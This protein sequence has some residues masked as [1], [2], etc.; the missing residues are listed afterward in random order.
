MR[1]ERL[2]LNLLVA[3]AVLI[4]ERSVSAA[5]RRLH[6]SQPAV[7][8]ALN[9]LRDFFGDELLVQS[10]RQMV[11][12]P[13]AEE[14]AGPVNDALMLIRTRITTPARF[15]PER[16]E[17]TFRVIA[18]DYVFLVFLAEMVAGLAKTAPGLSFEILSPEERTMD[19]LDRGEADLLITIDTRVRPDFPR[20]E[21]F[22]DEQAVICWS[23][24]R[25]A[26]GIDREAFGAAGHA[27][28]YFGPAR[29]PA[30]SELYFEQHAIDRRIEVYVPTFTMLPDAVIGTERLATIQRRYAV[31]CARVMPISVLPVPYPVPM[32]TE[33]AQWHSMRSQ[34]AGVQWLVKTIEQAAGAL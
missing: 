26:A 15:D 13:K 19:L 14:L 33:V 2:D 6:L 8:G 20:L 23:G 18:S 34:D 25:H 3:L 28:S 4:E 27:V 29:A 32:L 5:A 9:R 1:F 7:S 12:T 31:R 30:F 16:V 11:L 21:L 10:G 17:R 22:K 24:S